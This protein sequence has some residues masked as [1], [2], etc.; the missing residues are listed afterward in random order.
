[1]KEIKD[2]YK[3]AKVQIDKFHPATPFQSTASTDEET[4]KDLFASSELLNPAC[5][6]SSSRE[7]YVHKSNSKTVVSE[8]SSDDV[9]ASCLST[10]GR[11][12]IVV[13]DERSQSQIVDCIFRGGE[14]VIE[15]RLRHFVTQQ[16]VSIRRSIGTESFKKRKLNASNNKSKNIPTSFGGSSSSNY[17]DSR[18]YQKS[19]TASK[20]VGTIEDMNEVD[21]FSTLGSLPI[22]SEQFKN[23]H[24]DQQMI[25]LMEKDL[26]SSDE[27]STDDK[28]DTSNVLTPKTKGDST[29]MNSGSVSAV[30]SF[31][32]LKVYFLDPSLHIMV[33]TQDECKK[34]PLT[35]SNLQPSYVVLVDPDVEIIRMIETYQAS[36]DSIICKVSLVYLC[37]RIYSY[38]VFCRFIF[39]CMLRV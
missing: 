22:T 4:V 1:M 28:I 24:P 37:R 39:L 13:K 23:L 26:Y 27:K 38:K 32:D 2:D 33:L 17:G 16:A 14:K 18:K 21:D 10:I 9:V 31:T 29:S 12:I 19:S 15:Q 20:V 6:G 7:E 8:E 11:I 35:F 3:V 36:M 25:L 30:S 34:N 5:A